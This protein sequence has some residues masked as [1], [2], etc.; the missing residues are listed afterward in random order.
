MALPDSMTLLRIACGLFLFPHLYF[1]Y[2]H[3][4]KLV[5]FFVAAGFNPGM[6]FLLITAAVELFAGL[7]LVFGYQV[8]WAALAVAITMAV[9]SASLIKVFGFNWVWLEKG[10]EY[11]VM[12][13]IVALIVARAHWQT[14]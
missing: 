7:A 9:A 11:T 3:T 12:W 5:A 8:K 10:A 13:T 1:K 4:E 6:V 2:A 14:P